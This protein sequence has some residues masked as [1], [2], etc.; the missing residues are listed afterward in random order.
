MEAADG[1][2]VARLVRGVLFLSR[3]PERAVAVFEQIICMMWWRWRGQAGAGLGALRAPAVRN[4][5]SRLRCGGLSPRCC[6]GASVDGAVV[7][8]CVVVLLLSRWV[9][10]G[11]SRNSEGVAGLQWR[12]VRAWATRQPLRCGV[13]GGGILRAAPVTATMS[14][15]MFLAVLPAPPPVLCRNSSYC[16]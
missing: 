7:S 14:T 16:Y 6:D 11:G 15:A 1:A 5:C 9:V 3:F 13:S 12:V 4:V 8:R 10:G 2:S